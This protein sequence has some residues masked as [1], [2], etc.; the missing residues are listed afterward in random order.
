M[1][2]N[3]LLKMLLTMKKYV[4]PDGCKRG[5]R[6]IED[7]DNFDDRDVIARCRLTKPTALS[8]QEK[9]KSCLEYETSRF[10]NLL[11]ASTYTRI[12]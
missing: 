7:F 10:V 9:L 1:L 5:L 11:L 4:N 3:I 12:M 6:I 8:T 2:G